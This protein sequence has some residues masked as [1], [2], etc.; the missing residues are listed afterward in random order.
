M[1]GSPSSSGTLK[2]QN[3]NISSS[4]IALKNELAS[5]MDVSSQIE[6]ETFRA[7]KA[8]TIDD[9]NVKINKTNNAANNNNNTDASDRNSDQ[10]SKNGNEKERTI[11]PL[12]E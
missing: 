1:K 5:K 2:K 9:D 8:T 12:L 4:I 10:D 6:D 11:I 7:K 3:Q